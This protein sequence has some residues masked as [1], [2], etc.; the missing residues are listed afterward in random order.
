MYASASKYGWAA[1]GAGV[2]ALVCGL[3]MAQQGGAPLL[4]QS[5]EEAAGKSVGCVACHGETDSPSMHSTGTVRLGCTDCHGGKAEVKPPA[6]AAKGSAEYEQAKKQAHPK[7]RIAELWKSSA[8]PVRAFDAWEKESKEYIQFVNPGD[9]RVAEQTCGSSGCHPR[10]VVAVRTSMMTHGAMLWGAALYNNGGYPYKDSHFG[11]SYSPDGVAQRLMTYPP[12]SQDLTKSKGVLPHLDPLGRWEVSQ[13]GNVLRVFERGGGE[14][15]ETGIPNPEEDPGAPDVKLSDRGLGTEL[16]TDPVFLGLQKTRLLDPI[17]SMPGTNDHPGDYRSSGCTACHVIYA[18]DRS[19]VHS[20]PYAKYGNQAH[21]AQIDPTIPQNER[22]HPIKH[23][24]TRSIPTSQCIVCHI[25]PGTNM[26]ASYLGYIW[27][28][29]ETDGE[30]MYPPKQ[31]DPTDE[32]RFRSWEANPEGAAARGLWKDLPFLEKVGSPE[33][34]KELKH[35]QFADFHGHGWVFR[36]VYKRDRKGNLLDAASHVVPPDDKDKFDKAVQLRDIHLEKGMHCEDCHFAQDNHGNG[37][38][39]GETRNAVEVDCVDCHGTIAKKATLKTSAAA[40]PAGGT[41]ISLLRTPWGQRRFYWENGKLYQRP[42]VD[43]DR[44]P[45]EVV[46]VMDSITPG[47]PHYNE[48]SRLAKTLLK[49]GE[50]WGSAPKD[51]S[52]LAHANSRMTC[53]TCHSSWTTSCFGCHLPMVAN[54]KKPMLHNEGLTTRNYTSYNFEVLRD[55]IYMLGIDGTVTKHRIAPTRS[56]CA[57]VVS[58]QNA[59]RDWLYYMQQTISAEGFSGFGFSTYYPHTVRATETKTCTDCH[60]SREGDNNAWMAQILMQGTNLVNFMGRYVYVAEGSKGFDAVSVAEHDDPPAV[61]GSDLQKLVY[62]DDYEKLEKRHGELE[63]SDHHAGNVLD[64]QLRGE[65]LY[66]ALGKGGFRVYDVANIDNKDFSEKMVTA[67]FSPLGQ[68]F[69]VKTK[70]A[71][72]VGSPSTLAVDPLRTRIP[73]NEEQPIALMY[74]FLYVTDAEEGLVV[75]G[76]PNLKSKSPGVL[77]LLDGNPANN[78]LKRATTFNPNGILNGARRITI[79]G[80]YA[81]ILCDRGVVVVNLENPLA[82]KVESEIP[83]NSAQGIAIQFRY[84]FVVDDDGLK[85]LDTTSLAHPKLVA[86]ATV[87]M[88]DARNI[89]VARTYAYVAAGKQGLAIVDVERP[90]HPRLDQVYD[91]KGEIND[92]RDVKLSMTAASAFAYLADGKNGFR[93]VQ[94]FAPNDS[95]NY[96]GF[97]PRPAPKLIAT[98]RTKGPALAVSKGIDRDRAVD[99]SGN[100]LAVFN[101]RGSRPFNRQEAERMFLRNG[102]LYTVTNDPPGP[103]AGGEP[104]KQV[105]SR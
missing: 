88:Q 68:R 87:P 49:D 39:Y 96:L 80:T 62:S 77:T 22:G 81:Y 74:G 54:A 38:L 11:E 71:T 56:T 34:N 16:R 53:Y 89:Y 40:A 10:E 17:L 25:H 14:R 33:F 45:W 6:G 92:T 48:K 83:L 15:P 95:P 66:A 4:R 27:W 50:T 3:L 52:T 78:F 61:Y 51:E 72:S 93:I 65:Y 9:L 29:N 13:P 8:N 64:L 26:V 59:N 91:A 70:N 55:D 99:E 7:P 30:H 28:D 19:P 2:L 12:P 57:V 41:D 103:P 1:A 32:E 84:A 58:S 47:N 73:A 31:H 98:Y 86:G 36:A 79:A 105:T 42:M 23:E 20:G 97:S 100:Q 37:N 21:S 35:T 102:E 85:V 63:E 67:P 76:D 90:E 94:L 104:R 24:F 75:I 44:A 46:Q 82:P 101:R 43:K 18:N 60:V 69:Y 5:A